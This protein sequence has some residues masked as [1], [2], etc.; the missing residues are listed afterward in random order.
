[1]AGRRR[2]RGVRAGT[3]VGAG[4]DV[5]SLKTSARRVG[6]GEAASGAGGR[7]AARAR[8]REEEEVRVVDDEVGLGR[9]RGPLRPPDRQL[10]HVEPVESDQVDVRGLEE[11]PLVAFEVDGEREREGGARLQAPGVE[12]KSTTTWPGLI[13]PSC[14]SI[15]LSL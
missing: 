8:S 7:A 3:E 5:A 6:G 15:S 2:D 13:R 1:M 11:R 14:S 12:P 9:E 4:S 10:L